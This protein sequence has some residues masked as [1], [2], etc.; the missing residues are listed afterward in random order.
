[1]KVEK[2]LDLVKK[3]RIGS[4]IN[5]KCG[6]ETKKKSEG[7]IKNNAVTQQS[8]QTFLSPLLDLEKYRKSVLSQRFCRFGKQRQLFRS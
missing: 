1:M 4:F 5:Q 6:R 7:Q 8:Y 3:S 2:K